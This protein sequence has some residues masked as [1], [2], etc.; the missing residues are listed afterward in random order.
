MRAWRLGGSGEQKWAKH[1]TG[2]ILGAYRVALNGSEMVV[3]TASR[4]PSVSFNPLAPTVLRIN[5]SDG[6]YAGGSKYHINNTTSGIQPS[7]R[8]SL[9]VLPS[10]A[11]VIKAGQ[12][13]MLEVSSNGATVNRAA[14]FSA[15]G[16]C[17]SG[18][19]TRLGNG[20]Y[21]ARHNTETL[22]QLDSGFNI[23]AR[24]RY[25][26]T[27]FPF[28]TLL[29]E[30]GFSMG[31]N[32]DIY[33][34]GYLVAMQDVNGGYLATSGSWRG[35]K[36]IRFANNG[37]ALTGY[38]EAAFGPN[39]GQLDSGQLAKGST[40]AIDIKK[41]RGLV[42]LLGGFEQTCKVTAIGLSLEL[43][44]S[45]AANG[46][47]AA[48]LD[49]GSCFNTMGVRGWQPS[50]SVGTPGAITRTEATATVVSVS[51]TVAPG[52]LNMVDASAVLT[53]Q[54]AALA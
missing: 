1:Y 50:Y 41:G 45:T 23:V 49:T 17:L 51:L 15:S 37:E 3:Y 52:S 14:V 7:S 21:L 18:T 48:T 4:L 42:H 16:P 12:V 30:D 27:M 19:I 32:A 22:V 34:N 6:S 43:P 35:V 38:G 54:R 46:T 25:T 31:I 8:D 53:W 24:F 2:N 44:T 26:T 39:I 13:F 5:I 33:G 9:L 10:G 36:I 47:P 11:I 28:A 29:G 20:N 40:H